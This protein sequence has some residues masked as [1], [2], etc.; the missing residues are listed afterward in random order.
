MCGEDLAPEGQQLWNAI[1]DGR[2]DLP[3]T[4]GGPAAMS[5]YST[6]T[7]RSF[8]TRALPEALTQAGH[9][10]RTAATVPGGADDPGPATGLDTEGEPLLPDGIVPCLR[11]TRSGRRATRRRHRQS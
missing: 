3:V 7:G 8:W 5:E 1:V 10:G 9:S 2:D 6:R 11:S 4:D